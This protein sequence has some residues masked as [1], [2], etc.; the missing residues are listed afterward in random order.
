MVLIFQ[1]LTKRPERMRDFMQDVWTGQHEPLPNVWLGVSCEDQR[2]ADERIPLLLQTPAAVRFVS[3]EPLLGPVV[4]TALPFPVP[5]GE[6]V[7]INALHR[8]SVFAPR[9]DWVIAGAESGP[10]GRPMDDDWVRSLRDQCQGA[11]VPFFFKQRC[12]NGHKETDPLLDGRQ[13]LVYPMT[14]AESV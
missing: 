13:W 1:V 9:I 11:N 7:A 8:S 2:R 12:H 6:T 10:K 14:K 3:C 4:L 5:G